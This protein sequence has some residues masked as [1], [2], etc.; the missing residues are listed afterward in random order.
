M[1][2]TPR[3]KPHYRRAEAFRRAS[4]NDLP[5]YDYPVPREQIL[6]AAETSL[7]SM[8]RRSPDRD[9]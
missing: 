9:G 2:N 1:A 7:L 8:A 4:V 6:Q 3:P 5:K